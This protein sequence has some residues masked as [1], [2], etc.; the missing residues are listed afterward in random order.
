M[1]TRDNHPGR[2]GGE[3]ASSRNSRDAGSRGRR[4]GGGGGRKNKTANAMQAFADD[5]FGVRTRSWGTEPVGK[6]FGDPGFGP[7]EKEGAKATGGKTPTTKIATPAVMKAFMTALGAYAP[8][9]GAAILGGELMGDLVGEDQAA[10]DAGKLKSTR[11]DDTGD[12]GMG[13][14]DDIKGRGIGSFGNAATD[15]RAKNSNDLGRGMTGGSG[16]DS[17]AAAEAAEERRKRRLAAQ[18]TALGSEPESKL[19]PGV[20]PI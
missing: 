2:A 8:G 19:G 14:V 11:M 7:K 1:A 9:M 4:D 18:Q 17:N 5:A 12:Q 6:A 3:H 10:V 15:D 16:A 20:L 13:R